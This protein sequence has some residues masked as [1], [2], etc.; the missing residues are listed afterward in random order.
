MSEFRPELI[1]EKKEESFFDS[2]TKK[3]LSKWSSK[4]V[5]DK[6][7]E[8]FLIALPK[9]DFLNKYVSRLLRRKENHCLIA[10]PSRSHDYWDECGSVLV[11]NGNRS[12]YL[13]ALP[14]SDSWWNEFISIHFRKWK[15]KIFLFGN[16]NKLILIWFLQFGEWKQNPFLSSSSSNRVL[17]YCCS[18][19]NK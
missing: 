18:I 8:S 1:A 16:R 14:K 19:S 3:W 17:V 2:A 15:K 11:G 7:T 4:H 13:K 5:A 6:K 9:N 12:L 10:L